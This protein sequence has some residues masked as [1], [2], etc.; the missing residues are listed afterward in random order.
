MPD[1]GPECLTGS[2]RSLPEQRLQLGKGLLDWVQVRAV[3]WEVKQAGTSGANGLA[4]TCDLVGG[5]VIENHHITPGQD[6]REELPDIGKDKLNG[7]DPQ[8]WLTDVLERVV[9]GRT[10]TAEL[11]TLLPWNWKHSSTAT[12]PAI[13]A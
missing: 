7:V 10:K 12:V 5:E 11:D 8:A 1:G 2:G 13:A 4:Y 9:S 6:G 3:G